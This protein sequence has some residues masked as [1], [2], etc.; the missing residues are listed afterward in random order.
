MNEMFNLEILVQYES[1]GAEREESEYSLIEKFAM[2]SSAKLDIV[3][4]RFCM[5]NCYNVLFFLC[6]YQMH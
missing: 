2:S 3:I 4:M 6:S 5:L 1:G